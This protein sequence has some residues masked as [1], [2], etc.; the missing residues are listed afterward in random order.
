MQVE[1]P[2]DKY[3]EAINAFKSKIAEDKVPGA[4]DPDDAYKY[5][6][7]G[8]L[9]YQQ[10]LNLCRP[11]T[12]E[13]LA[14]DAATGFIYCSFALGIS[15]LTTYVI[16]Y[17]QT[18]NKKEALNAALTAGLQVFG[19][20]FMGHILASQ[21]AS[22][23]ECSTAS[24]LIWLYEYMLQE[25]EMD[26]LIEKLN[27]VK[28]K[29]FR[30]LFHGLLSEKSQDKKIDSFVRHYF[31]EI[32]RDRRLLRNRPPMISLECLNSLIRI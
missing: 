8:K 15:F 10:A 14:Y 32:I 1:V 18:R 9:A 12:I 13:S 2:S 22:L 20:S 26:V 25:A 6:R 16:C 11:G 23:Q 30:K 21:L 31:E 5:I 3:Y 19:L 24:F 4:T 29:E 28:A 7:R 27:A 17:A